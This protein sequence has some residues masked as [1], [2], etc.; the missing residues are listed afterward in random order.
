MARLAPTLT[1]LEA[2]HET[3]SNPGLVRHRARKLAGKLGVP[4]PTWA[5]ERS[6]HTGGK[7]KPAPRRGQRPI[8]VSVQDQIAALELLREWRSKTGYRCVVAKHDG[9]VELWDSTPG[10]RAVARFSDACDAA[11]SVAGG[12]V[13]WQ[14]LPLGSPP[15]VGHATD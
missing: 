3:S 8:A 4:V 2:L 6:R 14:P 9:S 11:L 15:K 1:L 10:A 5:A 7:F 13:D 12:D